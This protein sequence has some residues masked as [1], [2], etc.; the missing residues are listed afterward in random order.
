MLPYNRGQEMMTLIY[1]NKIEK[2]LQ[3]GKVWVNKNKNSNQHITP[4]IAKVKPSEHISNYVQSLLHGQVQT[5]ELVRPL[6][7]NG[8]RQIL[9]Q[10][11]EHKIDELGRG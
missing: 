8:V 3:I 5:D 11:A 9:Q 7:L 2:V 10:A 1:S 4:I 6:L